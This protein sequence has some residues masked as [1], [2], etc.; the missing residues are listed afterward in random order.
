[1]S[2]L[3]QLQR[4]T[5]ETSITVAVNL[6]GTGSADV[7]TGVGFFDHML[8][9]FA[10]H[11]LIDLTI[12]ASGDLHVDSHHTIED[13]GVTLGQALLQALSDKTGIRR[14]G[15]CTLPM[16]E[17]LATVAVDLSGRAYLVWKADIPRATLGAFDTELVEDFWQALS[18]N[19]KCNLHVVLHYGRNTHHLIEAI[20][21]AAAR[22]LRQAVEPD[23]RMA[24]MIPSTKGTLTS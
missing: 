12:Q 1:M 10:K 4:R 8:T 23:P 7:R 15:G 3:A 2:R 22:A 14:Y 9:L 20:F 19:L 17:T 11:S 24:G 16:D 21:K 6:D 5:G 13:V 18:A